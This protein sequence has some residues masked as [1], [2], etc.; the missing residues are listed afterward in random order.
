M[1]NVKPQNVVDVR[2]MRRASHQR[3][4]AV[5]AVLV[6]ALVL[7]FG[8]TL[9]VGQRTYSLGEVLQVIAGQQVQGASFAVG[10]LRLPRAILAAVGGMCFGIAGVTF[11]T[12]L[13]NQ[14]AS[15]DIVGI[16]SGASAFGV[17]A[18]VTFGWGQTMTSL[19]ALVGALVTASAIYLL[20]IRGT[21]S[22]TRLILIGI[23]MSSMLMSIVTYVLSKAAAWDLASASRWINGSINGASWDR[24][25]PLMIAAAIVI[26][27]LLCARRALKML[28]LGDDLAA[29]LG[30]RTSVA[31]VVLIVCAVVLVAAAT[32]ACGPVSFVAFMS[33]PIAWRINRRETVPMLT[34]A[35]VGALI[36]LGA[37]FVGQHLVGT[38]YPVGVITGLLG[39]PFLLYLLVRTQKGATR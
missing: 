23:G 30:V 2:A 35:L 28:Q 31:R 14:L 9:M 26:P 7:L 12:L 24:V 11:Q 18:I 33:G 36:V 22:G 1:S 16:S 25:L 8:I 10:E 5:N 6:I 15:P 21:F 3:S 37:D 38:R 39:A 32:A 19:A 29:G 4:A 17:V 13:R 20:A 27:V 34:A